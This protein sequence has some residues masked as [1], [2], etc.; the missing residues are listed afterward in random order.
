MSGGTEHVISKRM[1]YACFISL[2]S[3][4]Q[5]EKPL[6]IYLKKHQMFSI[7]HWYKTLCENVIK[8]RKSLTFVSNLS[9]SSFA[10]DLAK[11]N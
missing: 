9:I 1:T 8:S 7:T 5:G 3:F 6:M 2:L 11:K 4:L 10:Q